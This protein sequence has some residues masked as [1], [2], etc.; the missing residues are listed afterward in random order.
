MTP[1]HV[2]V[3]VA[4]DAA[5]ES[6]TTKL[7]DAARVAFLD[8]LAKIAAAHPEGRTVYGANG[9]VLV[10]TDVSMASLNGVFSLGSRP[11][12]TEIGRLATIAAG[13]ELPWS[14]SVR[15]DAS[16]EV[17][18]VAARHGR[19]H[20]SSEP[21]MV[22][23]ATEARW[24]GPGRDAPTIRTITYAEQKPYNDMLDLNF[25]TSAGIF[26]QLMEPI[27]V[28]PWAST[29]VAELDG[30]LVATGYGI[31]SGDHIGVFNI[32][33]PAELRGYGYGRLMTERVVR[34]GFD[35]GAA[36]A[37]L[38]ASDDGFPLYQSMGFRSVEAWT[39]LN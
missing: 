13:E 7:A 4:G 27:I 36:T 31:R 10:I 21:L 18:E 26:R 1:S 22:W 15:G 35:A 33:V 34:D 11:D 29:Y 3:E 2:D 6:A 39:N 28:V 30:V 14:I 37:Y 24:R 19:T 20:Q 17:L 23:P 8:A 38:Q 16:A 32:S 12:P 9:T 25:A 5:D